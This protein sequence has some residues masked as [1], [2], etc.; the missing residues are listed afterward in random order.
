MAGSQACGVFEYVLHSELIFF[1]PCLRNIASIGRITC[2][3]SGISYQGHDH[4]EA[5]QEQGSFLHD[6]GDG[7]PRSPAYRADMGGTGEASPNSIFE[8]SKLLYLHSRANR[9]AGSGHS[10]AKQRQHS[11]LVPRRRPKS[12]ASQTSSSSSSARSSEPI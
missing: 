5:A 11:A 4:H 3:F 12:A 7:R 9:I 1:K 2:A 10:V 6:F 8:L